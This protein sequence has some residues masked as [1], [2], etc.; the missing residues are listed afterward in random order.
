M[1]VAGTVAVASPAQAAVGAELWSEPNAR[2]HRANV[3]QNMSDITHLS[4]SS[5]KFHG[6]NWCGYTG[7]DYTGQSYKFY[8]GGYY[9][10]FGA[11]YDNFRSIKRC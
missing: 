4:A 7:T 8:E 5:G 6:T 10:Y 2:G 3:T 9:S 1:T 11:P